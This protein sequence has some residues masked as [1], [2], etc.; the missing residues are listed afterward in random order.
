MKSPI[1]WVGGKSRMVNKLLP[2]FPKHHCYVEVF[3]G[4]GW[5]LFGK[6][7]SKVEVL[8]DFDSLLSNM[9]LQIK[10]NKEKFIKSFD[11]T[12]VS[13]ET[14]ENYKDK[15]KNNDYKDD[16]EKAHIFYYL[17]NASF[18]SDMKNPIFGT[19]SQRR[20]SLRVDEINE[21]IEKAYNR[22]LKVTIENRSFEQLFKTY[23]NENTF[24]YLDPPYRNTK[25]YATG[26]FKDEQYELLRD[27]CTD[28][29]GKILITI[30]DD[31]YIRDVFK[32]FYIM[33]N[34]A[35]YKVCKDVSGR[36]RFKELIITNYRIDP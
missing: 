14:F 13:R 19:K 11:Y 29:K 3:G 33:D 4:A 1:N 34:E 6:E 31:D 30:N 8:N 18:A 35:Y 10:N 15:W 27:C 25:E 23:N 7:P 2:I 22:L 36:G 21:T 26:K 24:F 28:T 5:V 12:L 9:W 32:D 17:V 20:N 16:I